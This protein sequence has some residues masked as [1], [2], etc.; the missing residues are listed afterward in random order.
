MSD[1]SGARLLANAQTLARVARAVARRRLAG[2]GLNDQRV[3]LIAY[4]HR[5]GPATLYQIADS[6]DLHRPATAALLARM[7]AD[8]LV[9]WTSPA[10]EGGRFALTPA[11][12]ALVGPVRDEILRIRA[13]ALEGLS[14]AEIAAASRTLR[15]LIANLQR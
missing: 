8:G 5:Q 7:N 2:H 3:S 10:D 14:P 6:L 13:E 12:S 15:R 1:V 9:S 4:L 11:G